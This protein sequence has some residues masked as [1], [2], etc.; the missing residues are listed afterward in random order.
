MY[1][2]SVSSADVRNLTALGQTERTID[3]DISRLSA[4]TADNPSQQARVAQLRQDTASV[5]AALRA[6]VGAT[7]AA[8][9][10]T[11]VDADAQRAGMDSARRTMQA[12][13]AEENRLLA[14][15]VR[16][17]QAA[18][19]R[20]Q[21]VSIALVGGGLWTPCVDH[22]AH[23]AQRPS[24]TAGDR[25]RSAGPTRIWKHKWARAPRTSATRMRGCDRSS[26]RRSTASSSST[27]K[28][29][30]EAFNRGA[31]RLFGY[32]G[33]RSDRPQRQAC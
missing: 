7:Q 31:E 28:G 23:R 6:V 18:V 21:F 33:A 14:D 11:A 13:R 24:P 16:A 20:L 1:G 29:R 26:I 3:V 17:D 10:V 9:P 32:P 19:R 2:A 5:M 4:L 8:R 30:I 15:R 27:R 22:L 12:M 25:R